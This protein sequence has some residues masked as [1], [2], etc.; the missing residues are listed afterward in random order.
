MSEVEGGDADALVYEYLSECCVP[1]GVGARDETAAQLL[2]G[3][4]GA[5][6][7]CVPLADAACSADF[8]PCILP[9]AVAPPLERAPSAPLEPRPA[10]RTMEPPPPTP[11]WAG[12]DPDALIPLGKRKR[13]SANASGV[14]SAGTACADAGGLS[15]LQRAGAADIGRKGIRNAR[16]DAEAENLVCIWRAQLEN[17]AHSPHELHS[18]AVDGIVVQA[19]EAVPR[20][21]ALAAAATRAQPTDAKAEYTRAYGSAYAAATS[22]HARL[23][24]LRILHTLVKVCRRGHHAGRESRATR[25]ERRAPGWRVGI[26]PVAV[27]HR[28]LRGARHAGRVV[29]RVT[30]ARGGPGRG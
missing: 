18:K 15:A 1:F 10:W 12:A 28:R 29:H 30:P 14:A 16:A 20:G 22:A 13:E 21:G 27:T 4:M 2:N 8:T 25:C 17:L 7:G 23:N 5:W 24:Y 6:G 19:V 11:R 26:V 3:A 9:S